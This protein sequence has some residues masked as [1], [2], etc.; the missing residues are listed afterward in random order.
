MSQPASS[1]TPVERELVL[2]LL[3]DAA[4]IES[5]LAFGLP[6]PSVTRATLVPV[7]RRWIVEGLFYRAQKL[8]A[9][10]EVRFAIRNHAKAIKLCKDGVYAHWMGVLEFGTIGVGLGQANTKYLYPDGSPRVEMDRTVDTRP[11]P[12]PA[13]SFFDQK[14]F[15]WK[16]EFYTR[17]DVITL[18]ADE[19]GGVHFDPE[20]R[21]IKKKQYIKEIPNYFGF[22]VKGSNFQ[23]LIDDQIAQG[24]ADQGRRPNIYDA[25]ELI[26]MDTARIFS[27]GILARERAFRNMLG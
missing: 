15:F 19:L 18:H 6:K 9:G 14:M 27:Q 20:N 21:R 23:M 12:Q 2:Q 10:R 8:A 17:S 16:Q 26:A 24:R 11:T 4:T 5:Q 22:D 3:E 25:T 1:L 7:L 13:K